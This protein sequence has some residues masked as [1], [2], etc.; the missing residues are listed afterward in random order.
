MFL[1]LTTFTLGKILCAPFYL[2]ST[3]NQILMN[4]TIAF[5]LFVA[6]LTS[7]ST[8]NNAIDSYIGADISKDTITTYLQQRM[9]ELNIPGMSIAIINDGKISYNNCLGYANDSTKLPITTQT[10]FEAASLSKSVFALFVM[11]FVEEGK[12]DLDKPLFQYFPH[13]DIKNDER[14]KKITARMVLSHRSGFPNWREN[15]K[16]TSLK[17]QFEPNT[18]YLYSGE[19]YQYLAMVLMHIEKVD[20]NGLEQ[21]FQ[22]RIA[23]P[24]GMQHTVFIQTPF[25]RQHKAE[26]YDEDGKWIDWQNNYWYKKEDGRFSAPSSIHT[27][28]LDFSK[29]MIAVMNNKILSAKSYEEMLKPHSK[30]PYEGLSVSYT[31]GFLHPEIPLTNIYLHTGNNDGFT[32]WYAFDIKKKWGF[33]M[34]TNSNNGEQ[35]GEELFFYLLAGPDRTKLYVAIGAI[36][37]SLLAMAFFGVRLLV[38]RFKKEMQNNSKVELSK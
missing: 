14:Y 11:T 21:L 35:L 26:P 6:L 5:L 10:I 31:L 18:N 37:I 25:T 28:P 15:E 4:K 27:E 16:D 1:V 8:K 23:K 2:F 33:V 24:L 19:G 7:C 3:H 29:W 9:K 38:R 22:N 30:V 17:T 34:F 32:S 13:P 36:L 20:H 12:L